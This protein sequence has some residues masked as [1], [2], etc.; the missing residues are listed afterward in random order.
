MVTF[1]ILWLPGIPAAVHILS[2]NRTQLG[3]AKS[4][5]L[6]GVFLL[7]WLMGKHLVFNFQAHCVIILLITFILAL[8]ILFYPLLP[9]FTYL[10]LL[11][12]RPSWT[13]QQGQQ[14]G[15]LVLFSIIYDYQI[16]NNMTYKT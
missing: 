1:G 10:F 14:K 16:A 9:I 6:S 2:T 15:N 13:P 8:C 5:T 7:K 12:R 11:W 3:V 4:L